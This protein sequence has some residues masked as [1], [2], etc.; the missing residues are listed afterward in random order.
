[1][2][3]KSSFTFLELMVCIAILTIAGTFFAYKT[4]EVLALTKTNKAIKAIFSHIDLCKRLST[5]QHSDVIFKLRRDQQKNL[6]VCTIGTEGEQGIYTNTPP[7][8]HKFEEMQFLFIP[9]G[10]SKEYQETI[11]IAFSSTGTVVPNGTLT[12]IGPVKKVK[13]VFEIT[14]K[15]IASE[16]LTTGS[17]PTHPKD[18]AAF[19]KKNKPVVVEE[20][21][22]QKL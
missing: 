7:I 5:H 3:R 21:Y 18:A 2:K 6:L 1:M 10:S 16:N 12:L 4:S 13:R 8:E 11:E 17:I 20:I 9:K 15:Y 19:Q 22:S 14:N